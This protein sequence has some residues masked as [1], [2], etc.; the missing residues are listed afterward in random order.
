MNFP[1]Q[2]DVW[3]DQISENQFLIKL[4]SGNSFYVWSFDENIIL[5][6]AWLLVRAGG[7]GSQYGGNIFVRNKSE[8]SVNYSLLEDV[9]IAPTSGYTVHTKF[10]NLKITNEH[11]ILCGVFASVGTQ[12]LTL[13]VSRDAN[14]SLNEPTIKKCDLIDWILGRCE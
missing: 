11:D 4:E 2:G 7:A 9:A 14:Q 12:A 13:L 6:Q 3:V 10:S 8:P 1:T 5:H